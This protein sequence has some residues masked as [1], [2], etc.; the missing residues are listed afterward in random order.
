MLLSTS[1]I[2]MLFWS[3]ISVMNIYSGYLV[4]VRMWT[5]SH[6]K[7]QV[8]RFFRIHACPLLR[9]ITIKV[10]PVCPKKRNL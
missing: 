1:V 3:C 10:P 7:G 8:H 6:Y 2:R 4:V 9:D 5:W